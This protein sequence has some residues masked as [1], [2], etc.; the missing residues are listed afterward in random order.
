M[1]TVAFKHCPPVHRHVHHSSMSLLHSNK[2]PVVVSTFAS[3]Q[4]CPPSSKDN[5]D[6]DDENNDNVYS[7]PWPVPSALFLSFASLSINLHFRI[8]S[9]IARNYFD[10]FGRVHS[11]ARRFAL[12]S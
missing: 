2:A 4:D 8:A 3:L 7:V 11:M 9:G 6:N 10:P 1:L 5:N 12:L